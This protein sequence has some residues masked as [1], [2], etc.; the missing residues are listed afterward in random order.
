[1]DHKGKKQ[2]VI[3]C[4]THTLVDLFT[5]L[6]ISSPDIKKDETNLKNDRI[7][8]YVDKAEKRTGKKESSSG[9]GSKNNKSRI[10]AL[11]IR[12]QVN[13]TSAERTRRKNGGELAS[14][15]KTLRRSR[16]LDP[17]HKIAAIINHKSCKN[18]LILAGAGIS[19]SSGIPDFRSP[20][21]GIYSILKNNNLSSPTDAFDI[22]Y[23]RSNPAVFYELAKDLYPGQYRPNYAHYFIKLLCDKGLLGRMYTQNIDG[24]ERLADIPS[25]KLVEAHGTFSSAT[26]TCCKKTFNGDFIKS[27]IMNKIIPKCDRCSGIIKPD[28]V[29]FGENLPKRFYKLYKKDIA[30]CD[31]VIVMGTSL[32]VE[33]FASLVDKIPQRTPRVLINKEIVGPFT[34]KKRRFTDIIYTGDIVD[35]LKELAKNAGL[36]DEMIRLS[37]ASKA[38]YR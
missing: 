5:D 19:T 7:K 22:D 32:Q 4:N 2:S 36:R 6:T 1:M 30:G 8:L 28:I 29:F 10:E 11:P 26:C 31:L 27:A 37:L 25:S 20:K 23:F 21:T 3:T 9:K 16:T 24:L 33:P 18:I 12:G 15:N 34:R 38:F 17:L 35:G 13:I 14:D